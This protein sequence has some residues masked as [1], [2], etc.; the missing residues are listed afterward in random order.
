MV[1]V[2]LIL[3]LSKDIG[4]PARRAVVEKSQTLKFAHRLPSMAFDHVNPR[5]AL[6]VQFFGENMRAADGSMC[7]QTVWQG[8]TAL[9]AGSPLQ[10]ACR[11]TFARWQDKPSEVSF[12]SRRGATLETFSSRNEHSGPGASAE[13]ARGFDGA[14]LDSAKALCG[15]CLVPPVVS[16]LPV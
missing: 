13:P 3:C 6:L 7:R 11:L 4:C 2:L 14:T 9:R 12:D 1:Q 8:V 16:K 15:T 5:R 10:S